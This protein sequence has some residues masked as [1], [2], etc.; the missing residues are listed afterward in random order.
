MTKRIKIKVAS[1]LIVITLILSCG[2]NKKEAISIFEEKQFSFSHLRFNF[3]PR[4]QWIKKPENMLILHET[5]KKIGYRNLLNESIW[6]DERIW[7]LDISKSPKNWIDSLELTY[8]EYENAPKYYNKFWKRRVTQNNH[9][10]VYQVV[11]EIKQIMIEN[12]EIQVNNEIV[13]DTLKNLISFQYPFREISDE[14][15]NEQLEYLIKIGLH[16]SAYN[17]I[18]S[19]RN[20]YGEVNWNN[21]K[22]EIVERLNKSDKYSRAWFYTDTK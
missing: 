7:E 1:L 9:E 2:N 14:E 5:F 22:I 18:T 11:K 15:A 21:S 4:S 8:R 20:K 19:E 12:T 10:T 17:L 13:N 6:N 16:Q 3:A